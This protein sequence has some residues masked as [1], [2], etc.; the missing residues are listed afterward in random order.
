M[1]GSVICLLCF[2]YVMLAFCSSL[3]TH[4]GG[5]STW[6]SGQLETQVSSF[7][8]PACIK[9]TARTLRDGAAFNSK[10]MA[11]CDH[12]TQVAMGPHTRGTNKA[13]R[14]DFTWLF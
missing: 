3:E 13:A 11:K 2:I 12:L 4:A 9:V 6:H 14:L 10:C 7:A 8:K 1:F 5:F